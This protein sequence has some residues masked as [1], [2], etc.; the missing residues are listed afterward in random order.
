MKKFRVLALMLMAMMIIAISA[1]A[2]GINITGSYADGYVSFDVNG[3][4]TYYTISVGGESYSGMNA[5][6]KIA[7]KLDD[8]T[9]TMTVV[10]VD[11]CKGSVDIVVG[12]KPTDEPTPVPTQEPTPVPTAEPTAVPTEEPTAVPTEEPTPVPTEE[13][14]KP[15]ATPTP[16]NRHIV[17]DKPE[18]TATPT[19]V[20]TAEPVEN[21][22]AID[23]SKVE[24]NDTTA[25]DGVVKVVEGNQSVPKLYARVT[26]VYELS[27]GDSF[28][29][30]A[31]KNVERSNLSFNMAHSDWL[32]T[33]V[34]S[35]LFKDNY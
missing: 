6:G 19:P 16:N 29:Y 30:C 15:V 26:W 2:D 21:K 1:Q 27:N 14:A 13:P 23:L 11:G 4:H 35:S 20:P 25:G 7:A 31:M 28:A 33:A 9:Y 34:K 12:A 32:P 22:Y 5:S 24:K 18:P 3:F 8:G 10:D 17:P